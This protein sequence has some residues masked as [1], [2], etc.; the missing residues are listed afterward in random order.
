M[1]YVLVFNTEVEAEFNEAF[2]WYEA[3]Q[4][5]LGEKFE[6]EVE[7]Q[8]FAISVNPQ[9]YHF[10]KGKYREAVLTKFPFSIVY[11][12]NARKRT[13]YI[14]AIYHTSRNPKDKY[15]S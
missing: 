12:V 7:Q 10:S 8:L 2:D 9:Y 15:R 13:V 5:G 4:A 1:S 14:S 6:A 11:K 3:Q